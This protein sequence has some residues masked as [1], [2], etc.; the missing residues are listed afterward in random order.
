MFKKSIQD[1][2][3]A[4]L[5]LRKR[6]DESDDSL[7][8]I[9]DFWSQAP[10]T[11]YNKNINQ[12]DQQSWPNPW[13]IL[14]DNIYDDFTV[15]LMMAYSV[16]YT[17]KY[18]DTEVKIDTLI[19]NHKNQIYNLVVVDNYHVLNYQTNSVTTVDSISKD[20]YLDNC[21]VITRQ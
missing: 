19:N 4:W 13:Q 20:L 16:K 6:V 17:E 21:L 2:L 1:R 3:S 18:K 7:D 8:L 10:F 14:V 11:P 12:Y 9:V 15:A 5:E